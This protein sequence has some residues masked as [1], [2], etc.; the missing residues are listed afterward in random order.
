MV[1]SNKKLEEVVYTPRS[2]LSNPKQLIHSIIQDL[3]KSR[4]LAWRLF[5]RN[6]SAQYRRS[7]LGYIWAFLPP[8]A[9]TATFVFLKAQ[10]IFSFEETDVPYPVYVFIGTVLWQVFVD[11]INSPI[12]MVV[13]SKIMLVKINF[14]REALII[15][16]IGEVLFNLAIRL[17]LMIAV[18]IYF[19]SSVTFSILLAPMGIIAMIM[20]GVM[21][22]LLLTPL[23]VLYQDIERG[24][25][26]LISIWFFLTPV[27]YPAPTSW[28]ASMLAK[29][30]P[31]SPL[32]ITT[33]DWILGNPAG[34]LDMFLLISAI[35]IV[36]FLWGWLVFRI[37]MPHLI[38]RI[39]S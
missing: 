39:G 22:G 18:M 37:A 30:N 14:P 34:H 35:T 27:V 31:V 6:I 15:A 2:Q 11:A 12:K 32:L 28:P 38:A 24:L 26:M 7:F 19:K 16:G 23:A 3:K 36:L 33:R 10:T 29:G 25:M 9:T 4:E 17:F 21:I 1:K 8:I 20:L 13:Q 5:I